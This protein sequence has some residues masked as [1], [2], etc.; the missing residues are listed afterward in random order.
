MG[1]CT[2]SISQGAECLD[3]RAQRDGVHC[4]DLPEHSLKIRKPH[5]PS[6]TRTHTPP[7]HQH[8]TARRAGQILQQG[9]CLQQ[10]NSCSWQAPADFRALLCL[11]CLQGKFDKAGKQP[12]LRS[13]SLPSSRQ[14]GP[15]QGIPAAWEPQPAVKQAGGNR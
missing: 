1:W 11:A 7:A 13:H 9:L 12:M 8:F 5:T 4:C 2:S 10:G 6:H 15:K 3:H 14:E